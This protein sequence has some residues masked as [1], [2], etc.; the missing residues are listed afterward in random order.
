MRGL[1]FFNHLADL[2]PYVITMHWTSRLRVPL[3]IKH[4]WAIIRGFN[5]GIANS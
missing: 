1:S 2:P 5:Q 4:D 3:P